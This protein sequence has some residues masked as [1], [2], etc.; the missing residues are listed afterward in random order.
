ARVH[1][2]IDAAGTFLGSVLE[3]ELDWVDAQFLGDFVDHR[4]ASEGG[5]GGTGGA[6]GLRLGLVHAHVVAVDHRIGDVVAA[7][8]AH[9]AGANHAAG[10]TA[11][12][13]RQ[14]GLAGHQL[15][16]AGGA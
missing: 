7:K 16:V 5:L 9:A 11:G 8:H 15:A 13:V 3:A 1:R 14:V 10:E 2:S 12:L 4:F 6:V